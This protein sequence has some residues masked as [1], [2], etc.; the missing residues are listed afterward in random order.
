MNLGPPI[1]KG[2]T[3]DIYLHENKIIKIFKDHLPDTESAKEAS[4]QSLAHAACLPVPAVLEVTS[5]NNKQAIIM[6][7]V[8]GRT[9]GDLFFENKSLAEK[10][11]RMSIDIQQQIHSIIPKSLETMNDKLRRQIES[12]SQLDGR[13]KSGLLQK[14][15]SI[16]YVSRLC[17]GDFHLFNLIKSD[18]K[19]HIIDWVDSSAG[20]IRA[21]VCR[22]Y[23][24]YS[25]FYPD[26]AEQYVDLYCQKSGLLRS[27]IFEW[28]PIIAAARLAERVETENQER[29]LK[30]VLAQ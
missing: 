5:V 26:L 3:A 18:E 2:N 19:I 12:A 4:K 23:L 1:A 27:E 7:F 22:T 13:Q 29:L 28:L 10:Y 14:L 17:H 24:L 25:Q 20:D 15:E 6:E 30:I 21:D 8:K 9:L 16:N 11:L